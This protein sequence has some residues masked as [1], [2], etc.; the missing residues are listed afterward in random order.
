M[1]GVGGSIP[2]GGTGLGL[3]ICQELIRVAGGEI[4]VMSEVGKGTKFAIELP[5]AE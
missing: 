2:R 1:E 4:R 5:I 3:T